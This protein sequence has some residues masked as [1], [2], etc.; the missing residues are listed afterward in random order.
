MKDARHRVHPQCS[1]R[2]QL[3][4]FDFSGLAVSL[5]VVVIDNGGG[6]QSGKASAVAKENADGRCVD[7]R[8]REVEPAVAVEVTGS[9]CVMALAWGP[10]SAL[11]S[12]KPFNRNSQRFKVAR[13]RAPPRLKNTATTAHASAAQSL[14]SVDGTMR[15]KKHAQAN[16]SQ[17]QGFNTQE[18]R[19]KRTGT[20][21]AQVI[22]LKQ[23]VVPGAVGGADER[24]VAVVP[25]TAAID[26]GCTGGRRRPFP[27]IS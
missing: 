13:Y 5:Q 6:R 19:E 27:Y 3:R 24:R 4:A 25:A 23:R 1:A 14:R 21:K 8:Y 7:V 16:A 10:T 20:A 17:R 22:K 2:A 18:S 15:L 12:T 26:A 9:V 11:R